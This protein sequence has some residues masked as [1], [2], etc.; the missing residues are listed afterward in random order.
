MYIEITTE[1]GDDPT[2]GAE[3]RHYYRFAVHADYGHNVELR[4]DCYRE[5]SRATRRHKWKLTEEPGS[6]WRRG[7]RSWDRRRFHAAEPPLISDEIKA[8]VVAELTSR[9]VFI[10]GESK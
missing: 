7:V 10:I 1:Q 3:R 6:E 5:E 9:I 8:Q 2:T 4:F